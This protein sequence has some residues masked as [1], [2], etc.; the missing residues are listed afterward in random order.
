MKYFE[1]SVEMALRGFLAERRSEAVSIDGR[2]GLVIDELE[3]AVSAGGK[4]LRPV[5]AAWGYRAG[6]RELDEPMVRAAAALELL[7]TFAL[8][9]DDVIDRSLTRRGRPAT[10]VV[11]AAA[12]EIEPERFGPSAA[13]LLADL[14]LIWAD[15]LL[16]SSGFPPERLAR[17]L[18]VYNSLRTEVTLGQ[19]LDILAAHSRCVTEDE[20][21]TVNRY[22]TASYTVQRPI[23]L[24]LALAGAP[25]EVLEAASAYAI[26]AGIAFQLRD[27]VLGAFGDPQVTGKPSG[28]DLRERK[29]T[30]LRSR[31]LR[32]NPAAGEVT[33]VGR[34]R[35]L[36]VESG[37]LAEAEAKIGSLVEEALAAARRLP[38]AEEL[39]AELVTLTER[40]AWRRS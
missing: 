12:A 6:G 27:D 10:H 16:C 5:L 26:P 39:I 33:D 38:V 24:G 13:I 29:P 35:D 32:H 4:R 30:W 34:L 15:Q 8:I 37:A 17:G 21:L 14:A 1:P 36:M 11:L 23:Q 31:T 2:L 28:E 40:L 20:A 19:Y 18:D 7:Q 9:Q 25:E 3:A 22:K